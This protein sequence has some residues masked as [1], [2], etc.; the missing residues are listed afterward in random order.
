M[1]ALEGVVPGGQEYQEFRFEAAAMG[2]EKAPALEGVEGKLKNLWLSEA[3]KKG[4]RIGKKQA[5]SARGGKLQAVGKLFS[6]RPA[7]AEYV[8]RILG[9]IWSPF[10]GVECKDLGRNHFL[11][12]FHEEVAKKKAIEDGPWTFNKDVIVMEEFAPNK[13]IDEYEFRII[14]I[15]T[16]A[17]GIPMGAMSKET[18]D[19]IGDR[20]GKTLDVDLDDSGDAMG[21]YMRIKVRIDITVPITR[22]IDLVIDDDDEEDKDML[23]ERMT[24]AEDKEVKENREESEVKTIN[25]KYEYLP[26]FC[27][28]CGII[29][30]TEK[31]CLAHG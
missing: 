20:I 22:F 17:Y 11:F 30:H 4:I 23:C 27:Y 5:Y 12:T 18:G 10:S 19:L 7:K 6:E 31:A 1:E 16:R 26:D 8:G 2:G 28:N 21:E 3:E 9:S 14:P 25:F 29:G 13:T 15:C 24:V